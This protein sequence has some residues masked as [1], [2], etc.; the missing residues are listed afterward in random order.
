[1]QSMPK[2]PS[3]PGQG[4]FPGQRTI[5]LPRAPS[6][7]NTMPPV[8]PGMATIP[9]MGGMP[10]KGPIPGMPMQPMPMNPAPGGMGMGPIGGGLAGGPMQNTKSQMMANAL[11]KRR[12]L[13]TF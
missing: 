2:P 12:N 11:M 9:P 6:A 10:N 8:N 13:N 3:L 5:G 1:M 7:M 4:Q